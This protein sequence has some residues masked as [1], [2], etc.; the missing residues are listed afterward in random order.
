MWSYVHTKESIKARK[1]I[2]TNISF[3]IGLKFS[4]FLIYGWYTKDRYVPVLKTVKNS[5]KGALT[6]S[7]RRLC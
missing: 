6:I 1:S 7:L 4:K 2:A 5:M 3:R